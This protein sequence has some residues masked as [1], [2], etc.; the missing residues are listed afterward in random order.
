LLG[1]LEEPKGYLK[2]VTELEGDDDEEISE[3]QKWM[4]R[5]KCQYLYCALYHAKEMMPTVQNWDK[6][7]Q[8][9]REK[10]LMTGIRE[11]KCS[12]TIRNWYLDFTKKT[13]HLMLGF[14]KNISSHPFWMR[15]ETKCNRFDNTQ[16]RTYRNYL[17]RCLVNI[18][19]TPWSH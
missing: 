3:Y 7:C 13:E 12:R 14:Q 16:K 11:G 17:L 2:V 18:S 6:C 8:V 5:L 10:M 9:A 4:I 15:T 1:V 19:T